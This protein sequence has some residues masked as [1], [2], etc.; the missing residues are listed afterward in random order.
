MGAFWQQQSEKIGHEFERVRGGVTLEDLK[1]EREGRN[2][3]TMIS[4]KNKG[5]SNDAIALYC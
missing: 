5:N 1:G 2:V 4:K 3:V